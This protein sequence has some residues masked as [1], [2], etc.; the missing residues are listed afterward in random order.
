MGSVTIMA[1]HYV[2][3]PDEAELDKAMHAEGHRH[4]QH[5]RVSSSIWN[6]LSPGAWLHSAGGKRFHER[7]VVD[8]GVANRIMA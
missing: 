5:L 7:I 3:L 1:S 4:S 6:S 2:R 8:L